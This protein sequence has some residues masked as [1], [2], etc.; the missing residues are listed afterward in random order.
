MNPGQKRLTKSKKFQFL[1]T[2]KSEILHPNQAEHYSNE[3]N[4]PKPQNSV[5]SNFSQNNENDQKINDYPINSMDITQNG[6]SNPNTAPRIKKGE[7]INEF[8][9]FENELENCP[10]GTTHADYVY[11]WD[12]LETRYVCKNEFTL[13]NSGKVGREELV[14]FMQG[15][16]QIPQIDPTSRSKTYYLIGVYTCLVVILICILLIFFS[17]F[18]NQRI[19]FLIVLVLAISAVLILLYLIYKDRGVHNKKLVKRRRAIRDYLMRV[20]ALIEERGLHW[21]PSPRLAYL[22]LRTD[23]KP[24]AMGDR[25]VV[26]DLIDTFQQ[27][28]NTGKMFGENDRGLLKRIE[29]ERTRQAGE[30]EEAREA[31]N[32]GFGEPER[33]RDVLEDSLESGLV[34]DVERFKAVPESLESQSIANYQP[35][36]RP[37]VFR[38]DFLKNSDSRAR[39]PST[40]TNALNTE[41]YGTKEPIN[42]SPKKRKLK[43]V[44]SDLEKSHRKG[45]SRSNKKHSASLNQLEELKFKPNEHQTDDI[46][47]NS[48]VKSYKNLV[49]TEPLQSHSKGHSNLQNRSNE[50]DRDTQGR[51]KSGKKSSHARDHKSVRKSLKKS[52]KQKEASRSINLM[53]TTLRNSPSMTDLNRPETV[54]PRGRQG[55]NELA[56]SKFVEDSFKTPVQKIRESEVNRTIDHHLKLP[57]IQNNFVSRKDYESGNPYESYLPEETVHGKSSNQSASEYKT[58]KLNHFGLKSQRSFINPPENTKISKNSPRSPKRKKSNFG[59]PRGEISTLREESKNWTPVPIAEVSNYEI[60]HNE[61]REEAGSPFKMQKSYLRNSNNN[62][63]F[64]EE[65]E[66]LR[67]PQ[68]VVR[69]PGSFNLYG[70]DAASPVIQR[71]SGLAQ[72]QGFARAVGAGGALPRFSG[73]NG[74]NHHNRR[75]ATFK[76]TLNASSKVDRGGRGR[77]WKRG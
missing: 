22:V 74:N 40:S 10:E 57:S 71:S 66:N 3:T 47:H 26:G 31:R 77:S 12:F 27:G 72:K 64:I 30:L 59:G 8:E 5:K 44:Q 34:M 35:K 41:I 52:Q 56:V 50:L 48:G 46:D 45:R 2:T 25:R 43:K 32:G 42:F 36:N 11:K 24:M 68:V 21:T 23:Y 61:S 69:S 4:P 29:R 20:N 15:L 37:K 16:H 65:K 19:I 70:N 17:S 76:S 28:T 67:T 58:L 60:I 63:V 55:F 1:P 38:R 54:D 6:L 73:L 39:V 62:P 75:R 9:L 7:K 51:R 13:L 49:H 33:G 14:Q 53:K 18:V